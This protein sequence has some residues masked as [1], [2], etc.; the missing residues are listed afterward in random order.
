MN[1]AIKI[2]MGDDRKFLVLPAAL[3]A[4]AGQLMSSASVY[5]Y[6][7]YSS[8]SGIKPSDSALRIEFID[9]GDL[10]P[11]NAKTL[12]AIKEADEQRVSWYKEYTKANKL[13]KEL[14]ES[15][16]ALAALHQATVCTVKPAPELT[17]DSGIDTDD[18]PL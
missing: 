11:A 14:A 6:D 2:V 5:E 4:V 15:K 16:A 13:E 1:K 3:A 9:E 10:V 18:L 17:T 8:N 12:A 7:G